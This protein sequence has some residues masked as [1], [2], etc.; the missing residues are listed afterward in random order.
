MPLRLKAQNARDKGARAVLIVTGPR[1]A[2]AV[3][4]LVPL[5]ADASLADEGLPCFT[6]TRAV[7]D[8][9]FAGTGTTLEDAQRR[10]DEGRSRRPR[11]GGPPGSDRRSDPEEIADAQRHRPP[12]AGQHGP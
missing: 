8:A 11:P 10:I 6:V 2:G 4:Q 1:T 9:L 3:D 5:Q 12:A 7:A